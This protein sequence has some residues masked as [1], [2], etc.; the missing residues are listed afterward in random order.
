[1]TASFEQVRE[2]TLRFG[3]NSYLEVARKRLREESGAESDFLVITRGFFE[4]DGVK[5]WTKF[6]TVPDAAD[7]K[8]WLASALRDV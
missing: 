4:K 6:V 8:E 3:A 7:V 1:M 5:R 2:S